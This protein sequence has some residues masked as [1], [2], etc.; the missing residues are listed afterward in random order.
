MG[1]MPRGIRVEYTVEYNPIITY[2]R[3]LNRM[4]L[5]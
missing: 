3:G 2:V 4:A 1:V 5:A